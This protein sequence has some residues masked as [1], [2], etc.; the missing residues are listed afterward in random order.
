[1]FVKKYYLSEE[2]QR[3]S[4]VAAGDRIVDIVFHLIDTAGVAFTSAVC[5]CSWSLAEMEDRMHTQKKDIHA[6][7]TTRK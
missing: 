2:M 4:Q 1:M 3:C 6:T 5:V 7:K